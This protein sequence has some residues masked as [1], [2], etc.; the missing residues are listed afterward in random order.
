MKGENKKLVK[1]NN[2]INFIFVVQN[3]NL[4][5]KYCFELNH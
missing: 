2:N 1:S 4:L 3:K 5:K